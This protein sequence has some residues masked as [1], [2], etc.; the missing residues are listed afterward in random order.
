MHSPENW[1]SVV[2]FFVLIFVLYIP[3][4]IYTCVCRHNRFPTQEYFEDIESSCTSSDISDIQ[5]FDSVVPLKLYKQLKLDMK[6]EGNKEHLDWSDS[7]IT[8]VICLETLQDNDAV[9]RLSC[10]HIFHSS[11]ITPWYL[12]QHYTCPLCIRHYI[13][14]N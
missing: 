7:F 12:M 14:S 9:R 4:T 13:Q 11:C 2:T 10:G 5:R 3:L 8:C 6:L 1:L